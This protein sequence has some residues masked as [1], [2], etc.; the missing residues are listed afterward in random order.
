LDERLKLP[1]LYAG[2]NG[3]LKERSP[4]V[5]G[6]AIDFIHTGTP[7]QI[8]DAKYKPR[9]GNSQSGIVNDIREISGYAR[10]EKILRAFGYGQD[11]VPDYLIVYPVDSQDAS[12]R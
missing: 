10:D 8:I 7:K 11:A 5:L 1:Y 9:Y 4:T 2:S 12:V 6:T 3:H